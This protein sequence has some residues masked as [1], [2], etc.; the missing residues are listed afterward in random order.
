VTV[1]VHWRPGCGFCASLM[2]Q[3]D[4]AGLTYD[5]V[6]IW[7]D[8]DGAAYVRSVAGGNETVPTVRVGDQAFVNPSAS[9][10]L[11]LVLAEAPEL[12]PEGYEPPQPGPIARALGRLLGS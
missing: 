11:Q 3:L 6:D 7:E 9:E 12:L 10:L 2:R 8:E 5:R 1:V 4:Q